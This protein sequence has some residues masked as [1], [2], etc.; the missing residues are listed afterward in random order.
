ML[1]QRFDGAMAI[2]MAFLF[3]ALAIIFE[4]RLTPDER[5][6]QLLFF[7][8]ELLEIVGQQLERAG[9]ILLV[10]RCLATF[11]SGHFRHREPDPVPDCLSLCRSRE[12]SSPLNF[13][14]KIAP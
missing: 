8:K 5:V 9:R 7:G 4:I 11:W 10:S 2:L 6:H 13:R 12:S 14:R 3:D 1:D